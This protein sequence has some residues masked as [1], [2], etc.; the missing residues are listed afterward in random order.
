MGKLISKRANEGVQRCSQIDGIPNYNSTPKKLNQYPC[1][2]GNLKIKI[3]YRKTSNFIPILFVC[4]LFFI[5]QT[6]AKNALKGE[7]DRHYLQQMQHLE[8]SK[9]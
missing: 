1:Y 9:F 5:G 2:F 4:L 7:P 8:S 6:I 3:N